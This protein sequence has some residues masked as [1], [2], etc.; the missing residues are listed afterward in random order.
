MAMDT[1]RLV[2]SSY[3]ISSKNGKEF[4]LQN[5]N[6]KCP[7]TLTEYC[8][9]RRWCNTVATVPLSQPFFG[10]C[11]WQQIPNNFI[12]VKKKPTMKLLS[13]QLRMSLNV[14]IDNNFVNYFKKMGQHLVSQTPCTLSSSNKKTIHWLLSLYFFEAQL[15]FLSFTE[16]GT[17]GI[18]FLKKWDLKHKS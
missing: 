10:T 15:N 1:P 16:V 2:S 9:K 13:W 11:C 14:R 6:S 8:S 12:F 17:I 7:Q 3:R 5:V 18:H 4:Q